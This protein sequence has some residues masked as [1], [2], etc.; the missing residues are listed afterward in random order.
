MLP[1]TYPRVI[2]DH[3]KKGDPL[4]YVSV[5]FSCVAAVCV[6]LSSVGVFWYRHTPALILAQV[7]FL[8]LLL[9]GL[10]MVSTASILLNVEP[11]DAS[12]MA[13]TWLV[14][15]GYTFE[16][17]PLLFKVSGRLHVCLSLVSSHVRLIIST[18][19]DT[20]LLVLF[21]W[22]R[23]GGCNRLPDL[24]FEQI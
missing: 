2:Q 20:F 4:T 5:I 10:A 11:S 6:V 18:T 16:L 8:Y 9:V 14:S 22:L 21:L 1:T 13:I 19:C 17:I 24:C 12:C 3:E 7:N 23:L 15:L